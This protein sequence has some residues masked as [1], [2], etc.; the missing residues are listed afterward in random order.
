[1][2]SETS[3]LW[4]VFQYK[5]LVGLPWLLRTL[6]TMKLQIMMETTM[7][8]S[9][10]MQ[11][12]PLKSL[13]QKVRGGGLHG[14][15]VSTQLMSMSRMVGKWRLRD[16]LDYPPQENLLLITHFICWAGSCSCGGCRSYLGWL[17]L[18]L[19]LSSTLSLL[20]LHCDSYVAPLGVLQVSLLLGSCPAT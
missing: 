18:Y 14:D 10:L 6:D 20:F 5:I 16:W 4:N 11:L 9:W 3:S 7:G 15:G 12:I 8:S 17:C 2:S 13:S 1:M 19:P